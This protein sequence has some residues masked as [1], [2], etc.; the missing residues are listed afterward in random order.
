V[1][2]VAYNNWRSCVN[3]VNEG[4]SSHDILIWIRVD[5][6]SGLYQPSPCILNETS[7]K[8]DRCQKIGLL[9]HSV[10]MLKEKSSPQ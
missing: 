3:S 9:L 6:S 1:N 5:C 8:V 2:I 4:Y 7:V 10:A